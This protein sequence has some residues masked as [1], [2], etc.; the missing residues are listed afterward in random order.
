MKFQNGTQIQHGRQNDIYLKILYKLQKM[1]H[2]CN[3]KNV[4]RICKKTFYLQNWH[5]DS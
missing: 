2:N 1:G 4:S 5:G 3:K